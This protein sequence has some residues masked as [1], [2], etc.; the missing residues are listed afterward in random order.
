MTSPEF[1]VERE[2]G[3]VFRDKK[4]LE[5]A[6][7]HSSIKRFAVPFE[8]LEFLGDRVLGLVIAEYIFQNSP[9]NAKEGA[10][11]KMHSA[12][13]CAETCCKIALQV[14]VDKAIQTAGKHLM[15]N[16]TVL[17]DAMEALLGAVLIDANYV[18]VKDVILHLWQDEFFAYDECAQEPK[19]QLQ[20]LCQKRTGET[21]AYELVSVS[22]ADHAPE[23]TISLTI[24]GVTVTASG[25]SRKDAETNAAKLMLHE[26][27]K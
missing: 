17:A 18:S 9:S 20:E 1:S 27:R 5:S 10:M 21:P 8:R 14:G 3:Y 16:K 24:A 2:L 13:V 4:L 12:F 26:L 7:R 22:G 25:H 11:A 23:F 15:T 6:L 19:T